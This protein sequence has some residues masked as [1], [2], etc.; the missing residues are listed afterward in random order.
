M[1][2]KMQ[3]AVVIGASVA[4]M[5]A[6]RALANHFKKVIVIERD[7][8]PPSGEPRKGVP[9]GRHAHILLSRGRELLDQYFP[10]LTQDLVNRGALAGDLTESYVWFAKGAYQRNFH[11]GM[12][13][14]QVSRP[15][16]EGYIH[17]RLCMLPN[18]T[19]LENHDVTG[20]AS[21]P[22]KSG[23]QITGVRVVN[24]AA[25][26]SERT[27]E[28]D[29]VIDAGGRGSHSPAWLERLDY[30]RP[31]EERIQVEVSYTTRTFR[32]QP[33]DP[34]KSPVVIV[35]DADNRRAGMIMALEGERWIV[36]L[37]GLLGDAA[38]G[39]LA[40]F[41]AYSRTLAAPDVY[42]FLQTAEPLGDAATYKYAASQRRRYENL[43]RFPAGFLVVGDA[44]CSFNPIYGQGM[45]TAALEACLLDDCLQTGLKDSGDGSL[46]RRFFRDA[47]R[48]LDTPWAI[49]A[50]GDLA[51]P[52][53]EGKRTFA[54]R[55]TN[56][57][58]ARYGR[59]ALKDTLLAGE[60]MKVANL[61]AAPAALFRPALMARVVWGNLKK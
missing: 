55:L 12:V 3:Q 42:E 56:A 48:M 10:G 53:V 22:T 21:M 1:Q 47:G 50:G 41:V 29:L 60:F 33:G 58:L 25:G 44:L 39:D 45:T 32:R 2:A 17:E 54:M 16:L 59:A 38:P 52:E 5:L 40:G 11:S 46:R 37:G 51:I 15:M 4:G 61:T 19:V 28:A 9:Q 57:Y 20:L 7:V 26:A 43:E 13:A 23:V 30:P 49:A 31:E 6:A 27:L 34:R 36:G 14:L 24:R 18:I 35:A 8:L